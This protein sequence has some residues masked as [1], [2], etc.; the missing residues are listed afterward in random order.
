MRAIAMEGGKMEEL[1]NQACGGRSLTDYAKSCNISVMHMSRIRSG[2]S[3]PSKKMCIKL[4][5]DPYVKEIGLTSAD[6]M[7]AAGYEDEVE[8][9]NTENFAR[10]FTNTLDAL[11]IGLLSRRLLKDGI[12]FK[13]AP[14]GTKPNVDFTFEVLEGDIREWN[15]CTSGQVQ[16]RTDGNEHIA[17]Y[18]L[19]GRLATFIKEDGVQYTML[20][21]DETLY[22]KLMK[23]VTACSLNANI[24]IAFFDNQ[25]MTITKETQIGS[26]GTYRSLLDKNTIEEQ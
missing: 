6:F 24:T 8:V 2:Q 23:A 20:I 18:Y 25:K 10:F 15:I 11:A 22:N 3:K 4:C 1:I 26:S 5:S 14:S 16:L 12:N 13:V 17:L 7:K 19:I 9:E 21:S